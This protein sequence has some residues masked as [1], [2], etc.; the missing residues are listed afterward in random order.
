V[1]RVSIRIDHKSIR[2]ATDFVRLILGT[3]RST[4]EINSEPHFDPYQILGVPL[5]ASMQEID[6]RYRQL[7]QVWHPDKKG[8][9]LN[10]MKRLNEAY[11]LICQQR[12]QK[13]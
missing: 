13:S 10:A 12:Q 11:S 4:R 1:A 6:S 8:G 2:E 5:D 9:N 3:V 7:S